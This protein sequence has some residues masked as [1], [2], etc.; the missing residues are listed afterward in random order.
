MKFYVNHCE[1]VNHEVTPDKTRLEELRVCAAKRQIN[2]IQWIVWQHSRKCTVNYGKR[3]KE[4]EP[5][6][7][8]LS[9]KQIAETVRT[10]VPDELHGRV[11]MPSRQRC[12]RSSFV[13]WLKS[14]IRCF[15]RSFYSE[16][17]LY[18]IEFCLFKFQLRVSLF[19]TCT[20]ASVLTVTYYMTI[21]GRMVRHNSQLVTLTCTLLP[22]V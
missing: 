14:D 5:S 11:G 20:H 16:Y 7:L 1:Q 9:A 2:V 8:L 18:Q 3:S 10:N 13:Q 19:I 4:S 17:P 15:R 21:M 12:P 22:L 6:P